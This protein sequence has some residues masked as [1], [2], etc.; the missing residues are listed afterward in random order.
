MKFIIEVRTGGQ[1]CLEIVGTFNTRA[2]AEHWIQ[3]NSETLERLAARCEVIGVI[4]P[5]S[6]A[7]AI[8]GRH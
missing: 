8:Y 7:K 3:A 6:F 1:D 5:E 2:L 4:Q